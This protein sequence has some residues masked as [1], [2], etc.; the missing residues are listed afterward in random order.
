MASSITLSKIFN[1]IFPFADFL[2]ILQL[3][4]YY[5]RFYFRDLPRL[6]FRRNL[7][8]RDTLKYT[9]RIQTTLLLSFTLFVICLVFV[10][11]FSVLMIPL[12]VGL[13]NVVLSPVYNTFRLQLQ[14]KA[15]LYFTRKNVKTKIIAIA[16]SFGKT[17]TKNYI[18]ELIRHSYKTQMISGNINT[19]TGIASWVLK[20]F[21]VTADYLIVEMDAYEVGEIARS[22]KILP[23]DIA[24]LTNTGDQHL[25]RFGT[26]INLAKSLNEIFDYS[27]PQATKI[28]P[29]H[30]NESLAL[31]VAQELRIPKDF[32]DDTLKKFSLPERRGNFTQMHGFS[33]IDNSYNISP[34]TALASL[35]AAR[36]LAGKRDLVVITAGIPELG[37]ENKNANTEYAKQLTEKATG[38]ILLNSVFAKEIRKAAPSVF[39]VS[40]LH[41]AWRL[42]KDQYSP[43]KILVLIQ[44]ELTD[45][46]Y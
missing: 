31:A 13:A 35:T 29:L 41:Y 33:V 45:L 9:T 25:M 5:S 26:K 40:D 34:T 24:V 30:S 3:E 8:K 7:Q 22:C 18:Y 37:E 2:Y 42:I 28:H 11:V 17:T 36:K 1:F 4:E 46:Y 39:I 27:K 6:F 32:V 15:R 38:I 21:D 19:P 14:N 43:E 10:S 20:N 23:P 12:W 16:G 44:P